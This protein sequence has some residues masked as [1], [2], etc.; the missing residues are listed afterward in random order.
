[1]RIPALAVTTVALSLAAAPALADEPPQ[2][3]ESND[4]WDLI[5]E[6]NPDP[7]N[8]DIAFVS[9]GLYQNWAITTWK[10][11]GF[12]FGA[13]GGVGP[14]LYRYSKLKSD[15][16]LCVALPEGETTG[17]CERP[18]G[19]P[20]QK[21]ENQK[22]A[23]IDATI[24]LVYGQVYLRVTPFPYLDLDVGG[25]LSL[26]GTTHD[27]RDA[28]AAAFTKGGYVDLRVGSKKIKFGPRFEYV[29]MTYFDF[30]ETGW[31]LT[32]IMMRVLL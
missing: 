8:L 14:P 6:D 29:H 19:T 27:I 16:D 3:D 25:K 24:E 15:E 31:K 12:Y 9:I 18:S 5:G 11:G 4:F 21:V 2:V 32:P 17:D 10:G 7:P 1:M 13:G 20:G 30:N 22:D 23:S 26:G 28:P